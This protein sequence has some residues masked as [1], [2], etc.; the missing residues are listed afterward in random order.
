MEETPEMKDGSETEREQEQ[1]L[2]QEEGKE[3]LE[4]QGDENSIDEE[5]DQLIW[6]RIARLLMLNNPAHLSEFSGIMETLVNNILKKPTELKFR[7]I[8]STNSIIQK[9]ILSIIGGLEFILALG[10]VS[11]S[12]PES[13][14]GEHLLMA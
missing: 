12:D 13:V 4:K 9:K 14:T 8:R 7:T 3:N 6:E 1:V 2:E 11:A 5:Y 10:F